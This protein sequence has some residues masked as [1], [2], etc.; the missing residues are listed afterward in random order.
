L[1]LKNLPVL[2]EKGIEVNNLLKSDIFRF[3]FDFDE[4]PGTH[5]NDSD[6]S[7]PYNESIFNIRQH[8]STV[9]PE[10]EFEEATNEDGS[11]KDPS[12]DSSKIYKIKYSINLLP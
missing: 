11:M 6:Q 2:V 3:D 12:I 8:Y 1:F 10:P 4:W 9:F 7:R 5:P